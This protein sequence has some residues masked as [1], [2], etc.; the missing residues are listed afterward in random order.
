MH[1]EHPEGAPPSP[2]RVAIVD[3]QPLYRDMLASVLS[4]TA[5]L[6][7]VVVAEGA[8]EARRQISRHQIDVAILDVDLVDGSGVGLGIQLRRVD[9]SIGIVLISAQD[10]MELLLDLP[11]DVRRGWSYL[12][13]NSPLTSTDTI[14]QAVLA[15]ARG[16]TVLDPQL[17][18]TA[19]PR[20]GS[21]LAGLSP[22]QY[23]VLQLVAQGLSNAGVAE[24]LGI[25]P[26]SV[27]NHLN[28]IYAALDLPAENN[29]RVSAVLRLIEESSRA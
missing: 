28:L 13:K 4:A 5:E 2:V 17:V 16:E 9:A 19:L 24:V 14:V 12:S 15:T 6:E 21:S 27:E 1:S 11:A 23:Q 22:R 7:V 3:D 25:S 26:R 10:V 20:S 29:S 18:A 8:A